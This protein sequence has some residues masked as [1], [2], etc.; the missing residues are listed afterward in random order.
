M[1]VC[2]QNPL[3]FWNAKSKNGGGGGSHQMAQPQKMCAK[4]AK[5]VC[6]SGTSITNPPSMD[7]FG[8]DSS[9]CLPVIRLTSGKQSLPAC[10]GT[11]TDIISGGAC[12]PNLLPILSLSHSLSSILPHWSLFITSAK[13]RK[14]KVEKAGPNAVMDHTRH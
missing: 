2:A 1:C 10:L 12:L 14:K 4:T 6:S 3:T 8:V 11:D 7:V 9:C 13:R 5:H